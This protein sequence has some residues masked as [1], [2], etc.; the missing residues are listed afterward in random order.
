M[1]ENILEFICSFSIW[2][3]GNVELSSKCGGAPRTFSVNINVFDVPSYGI[4]PLASS[5]VV[6]PMLYISDFSLYPCK[7]LK[8][9]KI[10]QIDYRSHT[11]ANLIS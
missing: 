4:I 2:F 9:I 10:L 6:I 7:F 1:Y 3:I 5:H 11:F 8:R